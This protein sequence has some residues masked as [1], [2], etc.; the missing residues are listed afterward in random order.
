LK[1]FLRNTDSPPSTGKKIRLMRL[2][3]RERA[4]E[5]ER[6]RLNQPRQTHRFEASRNSIVLANK[7]VPL[8][9]TLCNYE[10]WLDSS[11][12]YQNRISKNSILFPL[13]S[14]DSDFS[15]PIPDYHALRHILE[16]EAKI[17]TSLREGIR[18][19][20]LYEFSFSAL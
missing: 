19:V 13:S 12:Y 10:I 7:I 1:R 6:E 14:L 17:P 2:T 20:I 5:R 9:A 11:A 8:A 4:S 15:V 16:P 18:L 3:E